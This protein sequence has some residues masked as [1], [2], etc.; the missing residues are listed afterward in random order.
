MSFVDRTIKTVANATLGTI[1]L[2]VHT[3]LADRDHKRAGS[4]RIE[5]AAR[6]IP[7]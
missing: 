6:N 4:T 5:T 7:E 1:I 2:L 3:L